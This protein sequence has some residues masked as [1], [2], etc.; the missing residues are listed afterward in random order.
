MRILLHGINYAP[1]LTGIGKYSGEMAEWLASRGHEV[2]VVT[3]PPYYP[4]W[5]VGKGFRWWAYCVERGSVRVYRCPLWVPRRPSSLTRLLHLTSFMASSLPVMLAQVFWHPDVVLTVEPA[6]F[7]AP[8]TLAT[9]RLAGAASWL[10]IQDFEMDAAFGLGFLPA[11]GFVHRLAEG[12]ERRLMDGFDRISSV[13]RNMAD[14][15]PA[16]G[17][18]RRKIVLFPNWVDI[19]A[20]RPTPGPNRLREQLGLSPEKVVVLY[21]GNMGMKQGLELLP[22]LAQR[23]A[24]DERIRF[25]FCGDGA[26]RPQLESMIA[27]LHNVTLLPLQP[28][29]RLNDLLNAADIH[30][31]P[32]RS[33]AADLVMPSKLTGMLASG[34]PIVATAAAGT[35]VAIAIEGCGV[36]IDPGNMGKVVEA[37]QTLAF[38]PELRARLG[39][40]ARCNAVDNLGKELVLERFETQLRRLVES[41]IPAHPK[42]SHSHRL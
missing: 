31:L 22:L 33:G 28:L 19:D 39:A 8:A 11:D 32:Q 34:R 38:S 21:A 41:Q 5:Q 36:A 40:A 1:E 18:D 27:G 7:C 35:Q 4:A 23:F 15:L 2:R 13:S 6:L 42:H 25:L 9:A 16:K 26:F 14:R 12:L 29:S 17:V 37:I 30:L 20:I 24:E 10:H 3:A